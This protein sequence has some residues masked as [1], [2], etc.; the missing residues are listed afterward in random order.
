MAKNKKPRKEYKEKPC[1]ITVF[2][3]E[4]KAEIARLIDTAETTVRL[5]F[6]AGYATPYHLDNV[7]HIMNAAIV[8]MEDHDWHVDPLNCA[9]LDFIYESAEG[10]YNAVRRHNE[11]KSEKFIF[12]EPD[13]QN[14]EDAFLMCNK[15][16]NKCME[17]QPSRFFKEWTA[18]YILDDWQFKTKKPVT[19]EMVKWC[20]KRLA[21][22]PTSEWRKLY[23]SR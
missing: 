15:F 4:E 12:T 6:K 21:D 13:L 5:S 22:L 20:V 14:L 1:R 3:Q 8:C 18:S 7:R 17:N 11:G 16:I 2:T 10:M 23:V 19:P 9:K